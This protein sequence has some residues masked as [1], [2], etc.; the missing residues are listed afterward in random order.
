MIK[1]IT[2][3][4]SGD[5]EMFDT[6]LKLLEVLCENDANNPGL[7][8]VYKHFEKQSMEKSI[9]LSLFETNFDKVWRVLSAWKSQQLLN[10]N[11]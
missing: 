10:S 5:E 11:R 8:D 1:V 9:Q 7:Q 6:Y 4:E 2:G 3:L